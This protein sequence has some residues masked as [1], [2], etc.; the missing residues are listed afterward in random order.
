MAK[1]AQVAAPVDQQYNTVLQIIVDVNHVV[2]VIVG[3]AAK[4]ILII[5]TPHYC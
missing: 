4:L 5:I 3:G 2:T 1:M